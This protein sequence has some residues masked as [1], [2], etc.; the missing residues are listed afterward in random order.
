MKSRDEFISEY[1]DKYFGE[2]C[3]SGLQGKGSRK[4]HQLVEKY[5]LNDSPT[6]VLEVGAGI[7]EH[8]P[9]VKLANRHGIAQYTALDIRDQANLNLKLGTDNATIN[10]KIGSVQD[11]PFE[12]E[13]FDRVLSTCLFHHID[14][15]LEA[16]REVRRVTTVRGE[17][18]IGFPTDPGVANQALKKIYT[19]RK[20]KKIG[21]D[22]PAFVYALEHRNQIAGLLSILKE[23]FSNDK[24]TFHYWPTKLPSWNLNLVIVAHIVKSGA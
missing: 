14:D 2:L 22:N 10:W 3:N 12:D 18:A 24:V 16:F 9:F 8:F 7:G 13:R 17:I 6:N 19:Y 15:P 5:W 11:M 1:Y 21:I 4:F 23:V 20:A